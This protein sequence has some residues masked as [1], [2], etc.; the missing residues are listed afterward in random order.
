MKRWGLKNKN[1]FKQKQ[2]K[3][4]QNK[5]KTSPSLPNPIW[6]GFIL[7]F[8]YCSV[9]HSPPVA[10]VSSFFLKYTRNI[11]ILLQNEHFQFS[12]SALNVLLS[13]THFHCLKLCKSLS[14]PLLFFFLNLFLFFKPHL[15]KDYPDHF[16]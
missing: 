9:F 1:K 14:K 12:P 5:N 3:T 7:K 15:F 4:R 6:P 10:P 16:F 2:N 13:H 8:F 11:F